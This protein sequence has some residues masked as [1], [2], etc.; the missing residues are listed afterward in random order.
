MVADVAGPVVTCAVFAA[1]II[2]LRK[3]LVGMPYAKGIIV[4]HGVF[5]LLLF[6]NLF[7]VQHVHDARNL[8]AVFIHRSFVLFFGDQILLQ[9]FD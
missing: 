7:D 8:F 5:L 4:T 2:A 1:P 3:L 6:S 9:F